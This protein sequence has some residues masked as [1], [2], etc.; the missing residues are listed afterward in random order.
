MVVDGRELERRSRT[1]R[2][3]I[4]ATG[5]GR[6]RVD[7]RGMREHLVLADE[8]RGDVLREHEATI[9]SAVRRE[10]CGKT[11]G[12]RGVDESLGATLRD[13]RELRD[14]H[15]QRVEGERERLAVEVAVRDE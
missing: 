5:R 6:D 4:F 12:E 7:A 3:V 14:R 2:D 15:R 1:H 8:R 9:Q 11:A 10:E 13:V